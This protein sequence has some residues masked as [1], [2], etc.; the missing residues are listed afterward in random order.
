MSK[1]VAGVSANVT[2]RQVRLSSKL[3]R[4]YSKNSGHNMNS[5]FSDENEAIMNSKQL[6]LHKKSKSHLKGSAD[7]K[8][9]LSKLS[10][11]R[12]MSI[13]RGSKSKKVGDRRGTLPALG[14]GPIVGP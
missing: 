6:N 4:N 14:G 12:S 7:R 10:T 13:A 11:K 8:K 9:S 1:D 3:K 5:E 2:G